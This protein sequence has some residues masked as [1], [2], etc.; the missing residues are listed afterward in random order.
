MIFP[1]VPNAHTHWITK[2]FQCYLLN[3]SVTRFF[4]AVSTT[5]VE[6]FI[7]SH[8]DY[9]NG[10]SLA[11]PASTPSSKLFNDGL[12]E[13]WIWPRPSLPINHLQVFF[14]YRALTHLHSLARKAPYNQI[15][16]YISSLFPVSSYPF[17]RPTSPCELWPRPME[18]HAPA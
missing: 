5:V 1:C 2:F 9:C 4:F 11:L 15:L 13:K 6:A 17:S 18:P 3:V 8:L 16:G 12:S 14:A 10:H 7:V